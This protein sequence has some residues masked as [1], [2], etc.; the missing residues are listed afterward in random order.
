[1]PHRQAQALA[2]TKQ[3]TKRQ[4]EQQDLQEEPPEW[5]VAPLTHQFFTS[6]KAQDHLN[7][8]I[9]TGKALN[10]KALICVWR[11]TDKGKEER[12]A[13]TVKEW[14]KTIGWDAK[15]RQMRN[16]QHNGY[17]EGQSIF[18]IAANRRTID[19][20]PQEFEETNHGFH[21]LEQILLDLADRNISDCFSYFTAINEDSKPRGQGCRSVIKT[22]AQIKH[23]DILKDIN[24]FYITN[25][26]P[27]L[28][29]K[30]N[31]FGNNAFAIKATDGITS[32]KARPIGRHEL[33]K[34]CGFEK[35][36]VDELTADDT[37]WKDTFERLVET[38][39]AQTWAPIFAAL[40][41]AEVECATEETAQ[42]C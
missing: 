30:Q 20:L 1:L 4:R 21:Y 16:K 7:Q 24:V 37:Q 8:V 27:A 29:S 23:G 18:L 19:K 13:E 40:Y 15:V 9:N 33:L 12:Q 2:N 25:V 35:S 38:A 31:S 36:K 28:V 41:T 14:T 11:T 39:S 5:I 3:L 32:Q 42:L 17:L 26:G 6:S 10:S 22:P 34:A